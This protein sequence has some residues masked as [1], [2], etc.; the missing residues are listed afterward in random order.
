[1]NQAK[2]QQYYPRYGQNA[3]NSPGASILPADQMDKAVAIDFGDYD[4]KF[5]EG[6]H[7]NP[8][9][10]QCFKIQT[11]AGYPVQSTN[12]SDETIAAFACDLIFFLQQAVNKLSSISA[13][14]FV[15][16]VTELGTSF[17]PAIAYGSKFNGNRDG[18][19]QVRTED[20]SAA[21]ECLTYRGPPYFGD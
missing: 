10:D 1:M 18:G 11:E 7:S 13:D 19:G 6:W 3:Y 12:A 5:D 21:C 15:K 2:Q 8:G 14:S 20:Y 16:A 9:R 4:P 17:Q